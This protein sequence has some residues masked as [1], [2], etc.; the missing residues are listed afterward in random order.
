MKKP[1]YKILYVQVLMAI[2]IGVL[3]GHFYP[4]VGAAMKPLGDGFIK[5]IKM[6]IAPV[7]FCTVVLGIAGMGDMKKVGRVSGKGRFYFEIVSTLALIVGLIVV[8]VVKPGMGMNADVSTLDTKAIASYASKA[9]AQST[10]DFIMNII[11][12]TVT[13]A[14]AKGDILQ[15]L[16]F[17]ILFGVALSAMGERAKSLIRILEELSQGFFQ[18]VSIIMK[19]APIGAFGAMAF[20]IGKYG[21]AS[22]IPLAKLMKRLLSNLFVIYICY[23]WPNHRLSRFQHCQIYQLYKRRIAYCPGDIIVRKR[24][25]ANDG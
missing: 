10:T 23:S 17:S 1:V 7:I 16:L 9:Q 19:V 8:N 25:T 20:T 24:V 22:L 5:L 14:F 13:D 3:L 18:V 21:L 15:V 4:A 11:P 6:I 2:T 12:N